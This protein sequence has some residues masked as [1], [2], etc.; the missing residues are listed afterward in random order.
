MARVERGQAA[1]FADFQGHKNYLDALQ[2]AG[3]DIEWHVY[4]GGRHGLVADPANKDDA[5]RRRFDFLRRRLK[6]GG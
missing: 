1:I 5:T 2:G 4:Q 6:A 3:K